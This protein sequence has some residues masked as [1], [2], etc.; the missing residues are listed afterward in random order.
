MSAD[1]EQSFTGPV[2]V[3]PISVRH[4]D[5]RG[6]LGALDIGP[7]RLF[8]PPALLPIPIGMIAEELQP[9]FPVV[10]GA[11]D[12]EYAAWRYDLWAVS[13]RETATGLE[14]AVSAEYELS[15]AGMEGWEQRKPRWVWIPA[16]RVWVERPADDMPPK[17]RPFGP[18]LGPPIRTLTRATDADRVIGRYAWLA[19]S[20]GWALA[21]AVSD[22]YD[23]EVSDA[24]KAKIGRVGE[25][26]LEPTVHVM[27][28][29]T[30]WRWP[31]GDPVEDDDVAAVAAEGVW[32]E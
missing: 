10:V 31:V 12:G 7:P 11:G 14:I 5:S 3:G 29:R 24:I 15:H 19:R 30:W 18:P 6:D 32:L 13:Q 16:D 27:N 1:S 17:V 23:V 22:V 20:Y 9:A 26:I 4:L 25:S 2:V 8:A 21:V 28:R